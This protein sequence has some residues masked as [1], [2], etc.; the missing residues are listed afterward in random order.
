MLSVRTLL[1][2]VLALIAIHFVSAQSATD[3]IN[4]LK[5]RAFTEVHAE[6]PSCRVGENIGSCIPS[7]SCTG[8]RH[9]G[10]CPGSADIQCCIPAGA[11]AGAPATATSTTSTS[12]AAPAAGPK[13]KFGTQTGVCMS[14]SKC[15]GTTKSG[16]CPGSADIQCCLSPLAAPA[17]TPAAPGRR[18]LPNPGEAC[19]AFGKK[20]TCKEIV[21]CKGGRPYPG[22]C[23]G[24][25][26]IQCCIPNEFSPIKPGV[27]TAKK[28]RKITRSR[29]ERLAE[30]EHRAK[31]AAFNT[32]YKK[33]YAT[34]AKK[35]EAYAIFREN[36]I[37]NVNN[38]DRHGKGNVVFS[39]LTPFSTIP[40]HAFNALYKG[41]R[42]PTPRA[43]R[44]L[45][46]TEV[47]AGVTVFEPTEAQLEEAREIMRRAE[48]SDVSFISHGAGTLVQE[49]EACGANNKGLCQNADNCLN[50]M[51]TPTEGTCNTEGE[52]CCIP[53]GP[54]TPGQFSASGATVSGTLEVDF[55][56]LLTPIKNQKSCGSCWAFT[57]T[58]VVESAYTR[59]TGKSLIL[60]PQYFVD[61]DTK[62]S[63]CGGG[64]PGNAFDLLKTS[65][66]PTE[67]EYPYKAVR[68]TCAMQS[69]SGPKTKGNVRI[70]IC[71]DYKDCL[72][73]DGSQAVKLLAGLKMYGPIAVALDASKWQSYKGTIFPS[74]SCSPAWA[75]IDHAVQLVGYGSENGKKFWLIRNSWDTWW[76]EQ[77]FMRIEA[78]NGSC[79]FVNYAQ[80]TIYDPDTTVTAPAATPATPAASTDPASQLNIG[81]RR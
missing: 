79:G 78:S 30:A 15:S 51:G 68:G 63:G 46:E 28:A 20:G 3:K 18:V 42:P 12:S 39:S 19:T 81:G 43:G 65:R 13:C 37:K 16:L 4:S 6:A 22:W 7:K 38:N 71:P 11:G 1:V 2:A 53:P 73:A 74:S 33:T 55:R 17:T 31:F 50:A 72:D 49:G 26:S 35:E 70:T 27:F 45:L 24:A 36:R 21:S 10:L 44:S 67:A 25:A 52:I 9:R 54:V 32:L 14:K 56:N 29:A 8:T 41:F 57:A 64:L 69:G 47:E 34:A 5:E 60:S 77:G 59:S 40:S 80:A 62:S 66:Q 75:S 76:G 23:G 48:Q 58:A 61:C